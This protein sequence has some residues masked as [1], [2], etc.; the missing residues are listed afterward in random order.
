VHCQREVRH[1]NDVAE[2]MRAAP[3]PPSPPVATRPSSSLFAFA[4]IAT[5]TPA[6]AWRVCCRGSNRFGTTRGVRRRLARELRR[7]VLEEAEEGQI[8][9]TRATYK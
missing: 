2:F 6:R 4:A 9:T 5:T 1:E 8:R 7:L 3:T